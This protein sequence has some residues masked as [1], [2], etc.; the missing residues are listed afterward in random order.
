MNY[1]LLINILQIVLSVL[2]MGSILLQQRGSGLSSA[3]GGDSNV[4][5]TRRGIEKGL[6][7]A[8]VIFAVL[9]LAIG[10]LNILYK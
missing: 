7:W 2:L 4:Y 9:F 5:K 1:S 8:T 10:L 3:F 6:M